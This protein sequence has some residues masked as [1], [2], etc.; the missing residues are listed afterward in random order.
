ML[1]ANL[2][3]TP[4]GVTLRMKQFCWSATN[5]FP[6]PS[7]ATLVGALNRAALPVPSSSPAG[8]TPAMVRRSMNCADAVPAVRPRTI[9]VRN[10]LL[11]R[12][13]RRGRDESTI[14]I[15]R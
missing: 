5:T 15:S 14:R 6:A 1:P 3:T 13:V 7:T 10:A 9:S 12:E 4:A 2:V 8:D 11:Q